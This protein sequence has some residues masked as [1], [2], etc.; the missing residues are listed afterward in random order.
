[1]TTSGTTRADYGAVVF[2]CEIPG[3]NLARGTRGEVRTRAAYGAVVLKRQET[4]TKV[5]G[6]VA[7]E[8]KNNGPD[9]ISG[10]WERGGGGAF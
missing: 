3:K 9:L 1:M 5:Y 8:W 6:N 10:S 2:V 4:E 7:I